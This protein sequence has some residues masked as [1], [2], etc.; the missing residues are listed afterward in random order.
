M[1]HLQPV[2]AQADFIQKGAGVLHPLLGSQIP[3]QKVA[4]AY[5]AAADHDRVGPG[6]EYLKQIKHVHL[7]GAQ[8]LYDAILFL[9]LEEL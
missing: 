6:R 3:F 4:I 8:K 9:L 7:A 2:S 1:E 5:L